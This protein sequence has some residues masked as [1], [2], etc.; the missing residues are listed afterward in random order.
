MALLRNILLPFLKKS[1]VLDRKWS[2]KILSF[3]TL[4]HWFILRGVFFWFLVQLFTINV[5]TVLWYFHYPF[6]SSS[7]F[8]CWFLLIPDFP[9]NSSGT[10][11]ELVNLHF[12]LLVDY[13]SQKWI[14]LKIVKSWKMSLKLSNSCA[15]IDWVP[16]VCQATMP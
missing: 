4:I 6:S 7:T 3:S 13:F 5:V 12:I 9:K 16:T 11:I 10:R 15:F 1:R 14:E 8:Q 2:Y